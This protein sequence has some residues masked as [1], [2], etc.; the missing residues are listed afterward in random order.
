MRLHRIY[1]LRD[2]LAQAIDHDPPSA[3]IRRHSVSYCS[4]VDDFDVS[5]SVPRNGGHASSLVELALP[6][7][8]QIREDVA[9]NSSGRDVPDFQILVTAGDHFPRV[10]LEARDGPSVTCQSR[11]TLTRLGIPYT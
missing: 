6:H 4:E 5:V 9:H 11:S 1:R 2:F 3:L 10:M 7:T 8:R